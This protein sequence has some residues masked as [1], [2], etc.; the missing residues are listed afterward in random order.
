M[1]RVPDQRRVGV[2]QSGPVRPAAQKHLPKRQ[3]PLPEHALGHAGDATTE[4]STPLRPSMQKH[5]PRWQTPAFEH[6]FGHDAGAGRTSTAQLA[7][8]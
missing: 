2:A 7:P 1:G 8:A 6:A 4:Q 3:T 5:L